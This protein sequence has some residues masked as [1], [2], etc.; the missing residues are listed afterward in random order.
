MQRDCH[1]LA[2]AARQAIGSLTGLEPIQPDSPQWYVQ[3]VSV[4]LPPCDAD[5]L[6]QRLY[7]EFAVEVPIITWRGHTLTAHK[8]L[9]SLITHLTV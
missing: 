4:P 2:H 9:P 7:N 3:M 6:M 5:T 8:T 1:E